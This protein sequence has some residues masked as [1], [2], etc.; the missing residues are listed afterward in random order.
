MTY[1]LQWSN[2][3]G[4]PAGLTA[5]QPASA[6]AVAQPAG[7]PDTELGSASPDATLLADKLSQNNYYL[8]VTA[9]LAPS[10]DLLST[11]VLSSWDMQIDCVDNQ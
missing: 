11:P 2:P 9:H 8:R 5:G 10:S 1:A 6:H 7:T 3:P 4:V